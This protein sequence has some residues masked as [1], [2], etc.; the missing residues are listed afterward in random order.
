MIS[1]AHGELERSEMRGD[2]IALGKGTIDIIDDVNVA[3]TIGSIG[4]GYKM[5]SSAV[6]AKSAERKD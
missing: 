5:N 6:S 1:R 3:Y 2:K 4:L